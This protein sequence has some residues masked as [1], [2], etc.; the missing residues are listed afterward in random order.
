MTEQLDSHVAYA[1]DGYHF[2]TT[3]Q[4]KLQLFVR[5]YKKDLHAFGV[6]SAKILSLSP[7]QLPLLLQYGFALIAVN[8]AEKGAPPHR[9]PL[10]TNFKNDT[11]CC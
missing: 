11:R 6:H 3:N 5:V 2:G 7:L 1:V 9:C 4:E 10:R 8:S